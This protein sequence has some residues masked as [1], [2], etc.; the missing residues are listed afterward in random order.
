MAR[1]EPVGW[2]P[3]PWS[4]DITCLLPKAA[5]TQQ[6]TDTGL[7]LRDEKPND[8]LWNGS[9]SPAASTRKGCWPEKAAGPLPRRRAPSGP[10][11]SR[12]SPGA[13]EARLPRAPEPRRPDQPPPGARRNAP[14]SRP[15]TGRARKWRG[16]GKGGR[17]RGLR[18]GALAAVRARRGET[19]V[20]SSRRRNISFLILEEWSSAVVDGT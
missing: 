14:A 1:K 20:T 17:G 4:H 18:P 9:R 6:G 15:P 11:P 19:T 7:S 8:R 12:A 5:K 10:R 3:P 13:V 16:G 2:F